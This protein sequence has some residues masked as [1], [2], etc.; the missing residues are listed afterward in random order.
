MIPSTLRFVLIVAVICYFIIILYFLKQR[1][2]NLKYT[3][4]WLLAGAVMGILVIVPELL[5]AIIHIFG[6]QD[7]MNGLFI[8][9]IGF[10]IMIL[11]S[12]T[13]IAS[14]Q[15]RKIRT[16]TQELAILDKR[17]R[18]VETSMKENAESDR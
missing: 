10:I 14:R 2:L 5:T 11:L 6:I 4:L 7:N 13:S 17:L 9:C 15:N 3:L 8:F 12:L 16:L 1:A 18:E